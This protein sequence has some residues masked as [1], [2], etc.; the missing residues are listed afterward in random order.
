MV[1]LINI[2]I[3]N[4]KDSNVYRKANCSYGESEGFACFLIRVNMNPILT[5]K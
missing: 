2:A 5:N 3:M 4:P 1:E